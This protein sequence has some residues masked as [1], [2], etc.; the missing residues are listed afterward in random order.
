MLYLFEML[1]LVVFYILASINPPFLCGFC[2]FVCLGNLKHI[3][4]SLLT[5]REL[6]SKL[7]GAQSYLNIKGFM[8]LFLCASECLTTLTVSFLLFLSKL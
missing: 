1:P 7:F 4:P 3:F 6:T 8:H 5:C 2:L